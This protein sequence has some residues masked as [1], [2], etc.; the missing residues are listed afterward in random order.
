M[1]GTVV[2]R[3]LFVDTGCRGAGYGILITLND[4]VARFASQI[5]EMTTTDGHVIKLKSI[6]F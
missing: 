6:H 2:T 4:E 3:K 5:N 1:H